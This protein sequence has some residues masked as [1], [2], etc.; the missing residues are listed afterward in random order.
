[1]TALLGP[2][3][4]GKTSVLR[5][6][7]GLDRRPG[8][9]ALGD[10]VWQDAGSFV[11]AH[12]R[13]VGFV[14]QGTGLLPH[15]TV[16]GNLD[17]AARRAP[18]GRFARD[19]IVAATGIAALLDRPANRLS[20]GEAQ[21]AGIAR[22]LLGQPRVLLLDEPL[23]ALD[24][25][26]R[27]AMV[28]TLAALF[29]AAEI[30]V[31]Y[32]T[33]DAA[34]AARLARRMVRTGGRPRGRLAA[35]VDRQRRV[36]GRHVLHRGRHRLGRGHDAQHVAAGDLGEVGVAPAAPGE[37]G[38]QGGVGGD[39]LQ[40]LRQRAADPVEVAADPDMVDAR[41]VAR[42]GRCGRRPAPA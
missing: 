8:R 20:G 31:V 25:D 32:V 2:S 11:A 36:S 37:F 15:L 24:A 26:A 19:A 18:P 34:E 28:E 17:Y 39:A 4:A 33:H 21:R 1:M 7:A 10:E 23:S 27:A 12:R 42:Y 29:A 14:M 6:V 9:I 41:D 3:G 13:R 22:A 30:P 35:R 16:A 38:E 5:A 40:P